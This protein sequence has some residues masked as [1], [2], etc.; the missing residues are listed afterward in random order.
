MIQLLCSLA[1]FFKRP[2]ILGSI[3]AEDKDVSSPNNDVRHT[4]SSTQFDIT[5]DGTVY[6]KVNTISNIIVSFECFVLLFYATLII[7]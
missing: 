1:S 6:N 4:T 3:N 5:A 7:I 2:G